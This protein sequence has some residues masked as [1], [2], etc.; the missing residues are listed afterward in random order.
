MVQ[1][2]SR[3]R[4]ISVKN[5]AK[6]FLNGT[7]WTSGGPWGAPMAPRY[8]KKSTF[9]TLPGSFGGPLGAPWGHLDPLGGHFGDVCVSKIE[10]FYHVMSR[11]IFCFILGCFL[12]HFGSILGVFWVELGCQ[13]AVDLEKSSYA[14]T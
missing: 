13:I 8:L 11:L 4:A 6:S 7:M 10:F 12:E 1:K 9:W 2:T 14:Q 5:E 3:I